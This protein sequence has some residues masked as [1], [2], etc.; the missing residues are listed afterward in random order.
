[1]SIPLGLEIGSRCPLMAHTITMPVLELVTYK[2]TDAP[3]R[4]PRL[5]VGGPSPDHVW[6]VVNYLRC[7]ECGL[8]FIARDRGR[9]ILRLVESKILAAGFPLV[10]ELI[11]DPLFTQEDRPRFERNKN[12]TKAVCVECGHKRFL[13]YNAEL[14][15]DHTKL[16]HTM[17]HRIEEYERHLSRLVV[18][19][20]YCKRCLC[21]RPIKEKSKQITR[22]QFNEFVQLYADEPKIKTPN[23]LL[24]LRN[25]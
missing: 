25:P 21:A 9:D 13:L 23:D 10:A 17:M 2:E 24:K 7:S 1:M 5:M 19:Y 8:K 18:Q 6:E 4:T 14:V 20:I 15:T 3:N 16:G 12:N 22:S 11:D